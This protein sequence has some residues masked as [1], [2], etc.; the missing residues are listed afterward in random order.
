MSHIL[1]FIFNNLD[2]VITTGGGLY[3]LLVRIFPTRKNWS[4]IENVVKLLGL[5]IKNRRVPNPNDI[6]PLGND[7]KKINRVEV[8]RD[9]HIIAIITLL[10]LSVPAFAQLNGTF[11]SVRFTPEQDTAT[12][13]PQPDGTVLRVSDG[14]LYLKKVEGWRKLSD[15][16]STTVIT[17]S[18]LKTAIA[19]NALDTT[20]ILE[21]VNGPGG[22]RF[23]AFPFAPDSISPDILVPSLDFDYYKIDLQNNVIQAYDNLACVIRA[24][25]G[26]WDYIND[27]QHTKKGFGSI[28]SGS[29]S[30][31]LDYLKTYTKVLSLLVTPDETYASLGITVGA[32]VGVSNATINFYTTGLIGRIRESGGIL[33]VENAGLQS[34]VTGVSFDSGTG[35]ATITHGTMNS[36]VGAMVQT[37]N[38]IRIPILISSN[39]TQMVVRFVNN[40][41][42]PITS[43]TGLDFQILRGS[44]RRLTT[45]EMSVAASNLWVQGLMMTEY[46]L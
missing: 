13:S 14:N 27:S 9:K 18:Q 42:T 44:Q 43:P 39:A 32:S 24:T 38:P 19:S 28:L 8:P 22:K 12:F 2:L 7:G 35:D 34:A 16:S 5:I 40:A 23:F 4:V 29:V 10:F 41:G 36:L 25:A 45:T 37:M 33:V 21:V 26:T 31:Q 3:E 46:T 17:Y 11:K 20:K 6:V 1:D 15:Q 30:V